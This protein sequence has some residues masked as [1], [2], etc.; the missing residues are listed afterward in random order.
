MTLKHPL[1]LQGSKDRF[2]DIY[3]AD[4][5]VVCSLT[6]ILYDG[7]GGHKETNSVIRDREVSEAQA[8]E[9]FRLLTAGA[10]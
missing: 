3:D 6:A 2:W 9:V 10:P 5:H 4:G 7:S 8:R 1:T